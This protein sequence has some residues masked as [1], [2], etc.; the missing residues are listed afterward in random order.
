MATIELRINLRKPGNYAFFCPVTKLHLTLT[1]PV[2]FTDRV[3]PYILRGLKS[4]TIIDVNN[5]INLE[6]G[7]V[8][9][10]NGI[11]KE[12]VTE[13]VKKEVVKPQATTAPI[14]EQKEEL[15]QEVEAVV[16]ETARPRR[17]RRAQINPVDEVAE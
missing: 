11:Q 2:G 6:T 1:N 12:N 15:S 8:E 13:E 10:V 3:S 9:N 4:K 5:M 16:E 14:Q 17:G 7:K